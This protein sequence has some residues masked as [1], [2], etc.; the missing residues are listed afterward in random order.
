LVSKEVIPSKSDIK[1]CE[2]KP[3]TPEGK[4]DHEDFDDHPIP[5]NQMAQKIP[6]LLDLET[7]PPETGDL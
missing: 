3:F 4:C 1:S 6:R 2:S 7:Q 5:L